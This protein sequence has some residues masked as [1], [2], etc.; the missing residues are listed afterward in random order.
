MTIMPS[1]VIKAWEDREGPIVLTTVNNE[2]VP[3]AIYASCVSKYDDE[4]V[5]VADNYF[6]KTKENILNHP[7][8]SVL[9]ITKDG[10]SY[11]QKEI[12]YFTEGS[13][14]ED[15]KCWNPTKHPGHAAAVIKVQQV[16]SGSKQLAGN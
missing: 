1:E 4:T 10:K 13:Y 5:I 2:G 7:Y 3:N 14:F 8:A 11:Q 12:D 9:F 6:K 15:M 16:F